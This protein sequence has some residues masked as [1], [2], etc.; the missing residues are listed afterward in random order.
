MPPK[1]GQ[2]TTSTIVATFVL[3]FAQTNTFAKDPSQGILGNQTAQD[4]ASYV[5]GFV[6]TCVV[7]DIHTPSVWLKFETFTYVPE[8]QSVLI[9]SIVKDDNTGV[10]GEGLT[11]TSLAELDPDPEITNLNGTVP[12]V[13]FHCT[14][15]R[16]VRNIGGAAAEP[17]G[18]VILPGCTGK[19]RLAK[20]FSKLIE[21][22]GGKRSGF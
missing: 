2:I 1:S 20:A 17:I 10:G 22:A 6:K 13:L 19:E 4:A 3:V 5:S 15:G 21:T 11:E 16:C 7:H 18:Q 14:S 8:K 12:V 9:G